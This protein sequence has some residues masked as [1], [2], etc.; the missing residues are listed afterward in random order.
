MKKLLT[1]ASALMS[2]I[3]LSCAP[4][5]ADP[6]RGTTTLQLS[7]WTMND[8]SG[9]PDSYVSKKLDAWALGC[10]P[11]EGTHPDV[12][13]ACDVL[14]RVDGW[15]DSVAGYKDVVCTKEYK[16]VTLRIEGYWQGRYA[17][18]TN[19]YGNRCEAAAATED[20]FPV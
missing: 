19:Y 17:D 6:V 16:P 15:M 4:A 3:A 13:H 10:F 18:W 2:A 7:V 8:G 20:V 14:G 1:L 9:N 12:E 11:R 5:Y